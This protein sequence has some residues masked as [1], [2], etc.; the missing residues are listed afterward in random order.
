MN[1]RDSLQFILF[2]HPAGHG[3]CSLSKATCA[4]F[5]GWQVLRTQKHSPHT[6]LCV[7]V[8]GRESMFVFA[9]VC[10]V[11]ILC[12]GEL[13]RSFCVCACVCACVC[14]CVCVCVFVC[15]RAY[16]YIYVHICVCLR[17]CP[18]VF[19]CVC[20]CL[21]VYVCMCVCECV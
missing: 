8:S 13:Y 10:A 18:C 19:V 6:Q 11:C 17:V 2:A 15:V 16:M 9:T 4:C 5:S 7:C 12:M 14:V 21:C 20:V 3:E 1:R